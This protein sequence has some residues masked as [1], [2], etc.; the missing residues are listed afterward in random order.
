MNFQQSYL[1]TVSSARPGSAGPLLTE[2]PFLPA[3]K[4]GA[5]RR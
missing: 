2:L 3:L 1:R 5:S 4:G